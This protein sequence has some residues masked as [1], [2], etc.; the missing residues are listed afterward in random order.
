MCRG[1]ETEIKTFYFFFSFL[2]S[3]YWMQTCLCTDFWTL[4][5]YRIYL[6]YYLEQHPVFFQ[7]IKGQKRE[8]CVLN[9]P[10]PV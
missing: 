2:E 9:Q 6:A 5:Y 3:K 10:N 7:L 4:S 1:M 8:T